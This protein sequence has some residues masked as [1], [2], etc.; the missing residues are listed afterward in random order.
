MVRPPPPLG[1][2]ALARYAEV[3]A[4][5]S[6]T[7]AS[8]D[9]LNHET[10]RI[11]ANLRAGDLV[12]VQIPWFRGWKAYVGGGRR[13]LARDGLGFILIQPDCQGDCEILLRWTGPPD[14]PFA[15][16]ISGAALLAVVALVW[17]MP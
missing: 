3:V 8:I 12:S 2:S 15:A 10:A 7:A 4:D 17:R 14:W 9:W 6:R 16:V 11:R 13:T 5:P 1:D